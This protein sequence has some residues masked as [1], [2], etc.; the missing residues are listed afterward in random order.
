MYCYVSIMI[1]I[2]RHHHQL[3]EGHMY[4]RTGKFG[5]FNTTRNDEL[6]MFDH[7]PQLLCHI[8]AALGIG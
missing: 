6:I 8:K 4:I 2:H 5:F 3:R 1:G 7:V